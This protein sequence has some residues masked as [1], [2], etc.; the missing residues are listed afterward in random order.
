MHSVIILA[1]GNINPGPLIFLQKVKSKTM[2]TRCII[3]EKYITLL[4]NEY[5]HSSHPLFHHQLPVPKPRSNLSPLLISELFKVSMDIFPKSDADANVSPLLTLQFFIPSGFLF[6]ISICVFTYVLL[7]ATLSILEYHLKFSLSV[8]W[9][10]SPTL[11][12]GVFMRKGSRKK[13]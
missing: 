12:I 13:L 3:Q 7:I 5:F 11:T 6:P 2:K 10:K 1:Q 4:V 9:D 8:K